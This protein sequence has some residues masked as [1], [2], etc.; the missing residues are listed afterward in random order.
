MYG[1]QHFC[2]VRLKSWIGADRFLE[3]PK[4][5]SRSVLISLHSDGFRELMSCAAPVGTI[6]FK[7]F[8][9]VYSPA[10]SSIEEVDESVHKYF[11]AVIIRNYPEYFWYL[12]FSNT[13]KKIK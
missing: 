8:L 4:S 1:N 5:V 6:K 12:I 9:V 3:P 11:I 10:L 7:Y 13:Y 2:L